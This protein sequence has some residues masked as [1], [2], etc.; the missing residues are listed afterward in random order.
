[1]AV[2]PGHVEEGFMG[3]GAE[4]EERAEEGEA[5]RAGGEVPGFRWEEE[6][7]EEEEGDEEEEEEEEEVEDEQSFDDVYSQLKENHVERTKSD[8]KPASG[9]ILAKLPRKMRKSASVK[10]AFAHFEPDDAVEARR[11]A[12]VREGKGKSGGHPEAA[13]EEVDAKAD[14]FINRF[15]NQLK[16]QRLDSFTR[17]REMITRGSSR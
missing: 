13:D 10:S 16:L 15:K 17:Y 1:M 6:G 7:F 14:D 3:P 4:L 8:A 9:E 5:G 2:A 11:P 12:T